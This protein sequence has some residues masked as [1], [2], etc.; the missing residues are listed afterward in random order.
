MSKLTI[1]QVTQ[2]RKD[3]VADGWSAKPT[4]PHHE[5]IER[6]FTLNREGFI[7]QCLAR[8]ADDRR[9]NPDAAISVW[10]PD[11]MY[12]KPPR[13]YDWP[14]IQAGL[15]ACVNCGAIDVDTER[16]SFAG[17]CCADC[18]PEMAAKHERGN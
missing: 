8:P 18:R 9:T 6:A 16:Y 14:T 11:G 10:G 13:E 15:R 12:I 5:S 3:A 7:A 4:Y 17:R 2:W 1:D